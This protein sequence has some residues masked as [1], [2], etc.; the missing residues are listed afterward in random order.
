MT[1]M[2]IIINK[3]IEGILNINQGE[4]HNLRKYNKNKKITKIVNKK[5]NK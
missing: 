2:Q 4:N 5:N 3:K 1:I